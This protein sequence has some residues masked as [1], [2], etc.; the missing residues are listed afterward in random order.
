MGIA[1]ILVLVCHAVQFGVVM[2]SMINRLCVMCNVG[3]DLF[4]FLSGFGCFY[5]LDKY[6]ESDFT[7]FIKRFKRVWVPY[8]VT[9]I[10]I[11][12][13]LILL[14]SFSLMHEIYRYTT[15]SFWT[16]HDADWFIALIIP[17][18][19]T[20]PYLFKVIKIAPV[21]VCILI[22]IAIIIFTHMP[23]EKFSGVTYS[24][25]HNLQ[26]A[27]ERTTSYILGLT[28]AYFVKDKQR[29]PFLSVIL[30]SIVL[31]FI[32]HLYLPSYSF[33]WITVIPLSLSFAWLLDR[34][35]QG[36]KHIYKAFC[37]MGEISLETYIL[38]VG[39]RECAATIYDKYG[40]I[41]SEGHYVEYAIIIIVG[42][43]LAILCN[44]VSSTI[45]ERK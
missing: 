13:F 1:T 24:I 39:L 41:Y 36:E 11:W 37:F 27:F 7:W 10:P 38:N 2:P 25:L 40:I 17:L 33:F 15:L 4:L 3:V 43:V 9:K 8:T 44:K 35:C 28:I 22:V 16:L 6:Y 30:V 42:L 18:Y 12:I 19:F 23:I 14:G 5:S 32:F 20:T 31:F 34:L 45:L 21:R 26:W 29:L